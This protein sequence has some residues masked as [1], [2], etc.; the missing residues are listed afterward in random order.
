MPW[1]ILARKDTAFLKATIVS[2]GTGTRQGRVFSGGGLLP[3]ML[4]GFVTVAVG[5]AK[6]VRYQG[7]RP[8]RA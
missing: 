1:A 5:V 4:A 6:L 2:H 8:K 3:L 7:V